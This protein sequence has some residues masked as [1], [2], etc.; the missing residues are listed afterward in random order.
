MVVSQERK[1]PRYLGQGEKIG[2]GVRKCVH[3]GE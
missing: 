1:Y 3:G 2:L